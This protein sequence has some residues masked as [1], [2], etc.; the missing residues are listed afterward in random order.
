MDTEMEA[1]IAMFIR[2]R[3]W[4]GSTFSRKGDVWELDKGLHEDARVLCK[5]APTRNP[6]P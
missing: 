4:R 5:R 1:G 3:K 6:K 2:L